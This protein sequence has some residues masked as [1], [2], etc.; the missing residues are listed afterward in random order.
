MLSVHI[1]PPK[2][3]REPLRHWVLALTHP[4]YAALAEVQDCLHHA[5]ND[6]FRSANLRALNLPLTT[7][8]ISSPMAIGSDSVPVEVEMFGEKIYL[9]DSMQFML[10][11]GCRLHR[12]G[13]FYESVSFRGEPVDATHLM[14]FHHAE[15]EISGRLEDV[16]ELAGAFVVHL[17]KALLEGCP[18]SVWSLSGSLEHLEELVS[19]GAF[20]RITMAEA[21]A[22]IKNHGDGFVRECPG[23]PEVLTRSGEGALARWFGANLPVWVTHFP[24]LSVPFYQAHDPSADTLALNADLVLGSCEVLGSGQRH[25]TAEEVRQALD[26]QG[27][28]HDPYEWYL[29][30]RD[31]RPLQTSGFGLG[32]ERYLMWALGQAD[33]RD[34]TLLHREHGVQCLP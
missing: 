12:P 16:M 1:A 9:V 29:E 33:I 24:A 32:L 8:S 5:V 25:L 2:S 7:T 27:L 22:E 28:S 21:V 11:F 17:T 15:C 3:W 6:F 31:L 13:V 18:D 23:S 19:Q 34:C 10:E 30:M 26:A 20:P 4:Y 14:Q